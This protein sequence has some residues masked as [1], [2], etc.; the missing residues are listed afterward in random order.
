MTLIKVNAIICNDNQYLLLK[1]SI[2]DGGFWQT[3][4]G[5]V[6]INENLLSTL[7]REAWE[8]AG[9]TEL[10]INE[11]PIYTFTW[12]KAEDDVI[13]LAYLC[14]TKQRD[15][16]LS[17]EHTEYKW[18]DCDIAED[19]VEMTDNKTAIKKANEYLREGLNK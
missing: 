14:F 2:E 1:R 6:E 4:T 18:V 15:V 7:R 8:E 13:E 10:E 16:K 12:K 3:M 11:V 9:I 5:T 19:V 17:I